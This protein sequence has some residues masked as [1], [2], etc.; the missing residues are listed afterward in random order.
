[1][2]FVEQ[3]VSQNGRTILIA[4][5]ISAR[6]S[7]RNALPSLVSPT[8]KTH[9]PSITTSY[10]NV[11]RLPPRKIHNPSTSTTNQHPQT[12]RLD[13]RPPYR[14]TM[15]LILAVAYIHRADRAS[16]GRYR[17]TFLIII[18]VQRYY[19]GPELRD[20]LGVPT[21]LMAFKREFPH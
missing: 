8:S 9:L 20:I 14:N 1:M 13:M 3:D 17:R 5:I 6:L 10:S 16:I 4:L 7:Y 11:I 15:W 2:F 21:L 12:I 19:P 18:S